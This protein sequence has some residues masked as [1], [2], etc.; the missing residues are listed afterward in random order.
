ME[1]EKLIKKLG[2]TDIRFQAVAR[3]TGYDSVNIVIPKPT[4]KFHNVSVGEQF[5]VILKRK[6]P[7]NINTSDVWYVKGKAANE[8]LEK[9]RKTEQRKNLTPI[10]K[11][12]IKGLEVDNYGT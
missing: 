4:V 11:K 9:M 3:R 5:D 2:I 1:N 12:I 6:N 8:F 10:E 7:I